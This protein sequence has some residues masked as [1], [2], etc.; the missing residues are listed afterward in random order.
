VS[1]EG[2]ARSSGIDVWDVSTFDSELIEALEANADLIRQYLKVDHEI[3]LSYDHGRGPSRPMLRPENPH[4]SGFLALMESIG[5]LLERRTIRVS[6]AAPP[7]DHI[8]LG[9]RCALVACFELL[10]AYCG[11]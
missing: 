3:F 11:P 2:V 1:K 7:S 9:R 4:A 8:P 5:R 10:V 6:S